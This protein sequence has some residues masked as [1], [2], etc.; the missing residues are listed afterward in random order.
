[1][2]VI[3]V[4]LSDDLEKLLRDEAFKRFKGKKGSISKIVEEALKAWLV[5]KKISTRIYQIWINDELAFES[6]DLDEISKFL[7]E[8]KL[9]LKDV[10]IIMKKS[11]SEY[12]IG[13]RILK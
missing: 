1:M 4:K 5:K 3:T 12:R 11:K 13:P 10:R 9:S 7:K 8:K 2:G 6:E